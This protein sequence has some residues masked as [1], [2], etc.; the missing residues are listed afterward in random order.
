MNADEY[1]LKLPSLA[2]NTRELLPETAGIY[3]VVD[4][5]GVV[6]YV[7]KAKNLRNR[8]LGKSHHRFYQLQKQRQRK[9]TIYYDLVNVSV[10]DSIEKRE[11][12]KCHPQLNGTEVNSK[13]LQP[14]ETLLRKT[15]LTLAP[16]AFILG[17]E[18]PRKEDKQLIEYSKAFGDNWRINKSVVSL[19]VIHICIN[20]PELIEL[21]KDKKSTIQ[22]LKKIFRKN[23]N[24]SSNWIDQSS[25][26]YYRF[27]DFTLRRLLVN[28]FAIEIYLAD[29]RVISLIQE[30]TMT[31][32]AGID[33]KAVTNVSLDGL[34]NKCLLSNI[35]GLHL[36]DDSY[37]NSVYTELKNISINRLNPYSQDLVR[38]VFKDKID[39]TKLLTFPLDLKQI[40]TPNLG[41]SIRLVNLTH[42]KQYLKSL[43][44]ERGLD[45]N[46]YE[47]N[48]YLENIPQDNNYYE[49][50][51]S[52]NI[53]VYVKSFLYNDLQKCTYSPSQIY[54]QK[55]VTYQGKTTFNSLYQEVYL[56]VSVNKAFWLLF[57]NYLLD[58]TKVTLNEN[59]GYI[60]K[61][62]IS[63]KKT[64]KPVIVSVILNGQ[65]KAAIPIGTKDN[66][67]YYEVTEVIKNR[68]E[69]SLIPKLKFT[70]RLM[71]NLK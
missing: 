31:Q 25:K 11:I 48:Q 23:V 56:A 22:F 32:L 71:S 42:K 67:S 19:Q 37:D 52:S 69:N 26:K 18:P 39:T 21:I 68:L 4:E 10:L 60:K 8:W 9:F 50:N 3:Y 6:W 5:N 40:E 36:K 33:I 63:S 24:Y 43:L 65:W 45:L 55:L 1:I 34:K 13:R 15:L 27:S 62:Y 54:G 28:G 17:V 58:F 49:S 38:I 51:R 59:E 14:T 20:L 47:V 44:I 61:H 2:L 64:L 35:I 29:Q 66:M 70:F 30:Y 53:I 57:E 46:K 16:Y 41:L 12:D 7:G